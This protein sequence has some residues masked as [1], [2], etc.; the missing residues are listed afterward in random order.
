VNNSL[1]DSNTDI[2]FD[3]VNE[4]VNRSFENAQ[5]P[6]AHTGRRVNKK[7]FEEW[8]VKFPWLILSKNQRTN[9]SQV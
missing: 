5:K 6:T 7:M 4:I 3:L 9:D 2:A 1:T 8:T